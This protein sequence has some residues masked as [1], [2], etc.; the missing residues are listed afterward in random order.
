MSEAPSGGGTFSLYIH[1]P[2]CAGLCDYCDFYS[3]P[4]SPEDHRTGPFV[5]ALLIEAAEALRAYGAPQVPTVFIGGGTPS[6]LGADRM[7]RLLAGLRS[8][9]PGKPEEL[10]V[11]ANPE[12]ADRDFLDTCREGGVTRISLGVQTFH[13]PSRRALHRVGEGRFLRERLHLAAEL[14]GENFS[15]DLITGLPLQ[16]E[17]ILRDDLETL[18]SFRPGHVSLYSLTVEEGTALARR[19]RSFLPPPDKADRLWIRGRDFLEAA[20]YEQYEVSNF[21]L[22][23]KRCRHNIRYWRMENWLGL[24]PAASGTLVDDRTGTGRRYTVNPDVD[25]W[26]AAHVSGGADPGGAGLASRTEEYLDRPTLMKESLL[27]GF[28]FIDGPDE[29]AFRRRFGLSLEDAIPRTLDAWRRR[30]LM[31]RDRAALNRAGL[32]LLHPFL[33][34]A[35]GEIA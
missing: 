31:R 33:M 25:A 8:L 35:F 14:F 26:L 11:E 10:T 21:S 28:R 12:S 22:P 13:E 19:P 16:D 6:V 9:L 5:E 3:V 24:G 18:L 7:K 17:K 1:I 29:A 23:G 30:D 27:M 32:L 4:V 20:G 2:F 15:A 34:D